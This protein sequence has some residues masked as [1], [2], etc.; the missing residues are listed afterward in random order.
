[1]TPAEEQRPGLS[2]A[3]VIG[4]CPLVVKAQT[5]LTGAVLGSMFLVVLLLCVSGLSA[6]RRYVSYGFRLPVML[7]LSTT[8]VLVLDLFMQACWYEMRE[9]LGIY[10]PL[11]AMNSFLLLAMEQRAFTS[12]TVQALK[13][14]LA[15]AMFMLGFAVLV[16]TGRELLGRGALL[17]DIE[18]VL[19]GWS[20]WATGGAGYGLLAGAPG[21]FLLLGLCIALVNRVTELDR[22]SFTQQPDAIKHRRSRP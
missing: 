14:V 16:G 21:V 11:I 4:L 10:L 8:C 12:N 9:N 20:G 3:I 13:T 18:Q 15:P 1:V 6:C 7:L 22:F 2:G 17:S 19:P 5:L